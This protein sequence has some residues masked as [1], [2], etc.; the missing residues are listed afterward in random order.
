[1]ATL[2][3]DTTYFLTVGVLG[4]SPLW[5]ESSTDHV[6]KLEPLAARALQE[7]GGRVERI[8]AMVGPG[9]FTG[10]RAGLAFATGLSLS[11]GVPLSAGSLLFAEDV[12]ARAEG[13]EGPVIAV[14]NARRRQAYFQL[15]SEAG[16]ELSPMDISSPAKIANA[17]LSLGRPAALVGLPGEYFDKIASALSE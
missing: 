6:E 17:A 3:I 8:E 2:L 16:E 10:L 1:M 15:F 9:P 13:A 14:N 11:L 4:Q 5:V 7:A 12:W